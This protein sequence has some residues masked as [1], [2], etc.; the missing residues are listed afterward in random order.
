MTPEQYE[1][2][3][4]LF[5]AAREKD[6][7]QRASFLR[8]ACDDDLVRGEVE[9]LL[10]NDEKADTFLKTPALGS[11]FVVAHPESFAS[12]P[13]GELD[14]GRAPSDMT[15]TSVQRHPKRLGRY[16]ILD[17][18]G[19]G[20][21]GVVYRAEQDN[22]RRTVALKVI[23]PGIESPEVLKRFEHEGQVLGWLQHPGIAQIYEAGTA[24]A[25]QGPQP[26]FA[27]ELVRGTPLTDYAHT[28]RQGVRQR[29]ELIASV[30]DAVHHAHQK[31]VIHR[32]LKPTNI[33]VEESG[34][35]KILD[36][37]VARAT[38]AD[39]RTTTLQ[40]AAGQL[41]GTLAYMS[42]EQIGGDP[43]ELDTRS[44]VYALGAISYE[45]LTG[46]VPVDV[47]R[48]T[49]PQAA[50]AIVEQEP[51][52]LRSVN[53][54]YR[55]DVEAI[56][57][58]ALEKDKSR[59]Y[60]SAAELAADI[61]RY[62]AN[63][64]ISARPVTTAYQLRKFAQRNKALVGGLAAVFVVL[65]I[66]IIGTSSQTVRATRERNRARDA[67]RLADQRRLE[68]ERQHT[69]ALRQTAIAQA[70]NDFLNND[71]LAAVEPEEQGRDVTVRQVL[72]RASAAIGGKFDNQPL[73]EAAVHTTIGQAY[74]SLGLYDEAEPHLDAAVEIGKRVQGEEH[75]ETLASLSN[76]ALLRKRQG[77]LKE[78]ERIARH[79]VETSRRVLGEEYPQTIQATN[80]LAVL[81]QV[82]GQPEEAEALIRRTVETQQRTHGND[83]P[84]TLTAMNNLAIFLIDNGKAEQ[85][86]P[87]LRQALET[88]RRVLRPE[89]PDTITTLSNLAQALWATS[90]PLEATPLFRQVVD[91]RR[92]VL[93]NDHPDTLEAMNNLA[94]ILRRTGTLA[95]SEA[96]FRETLAAQR[97]C[98]GQD[99]YKTLSTMGNLA[100]VLRDQKQ[101]EEGETLL[102]QCLE[103]LRGK[104]GAGHPK[105]LAAMNNLATLLQ[106]AGKLD[107][108]EPLLREALDTLR[109]LVGEEHP[110]VL[111]MMNNLAYQL[112]WQ[113]K[114]EEAA[115]MHKRAVELATRALPDGHWHIGVFQGAYGDCLLDLKRYDEAEEQYLASYECLKAVF[116]ETQGAAADQGAEAPRDSA[117]AATGTPGTVQGA[118]HPVVRRAVE[119]LAALYSTW[120][121]PEEAA[122]W[123]AKLP[124]T[125]PA[126]PPEG[127]P[128]AP[129][130]TSGE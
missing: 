9:S 90:R 34:Q 32:D 66:G 35:P 65:V 85:A 1:Q 88:Q 100:G 23:R 53:R 89:H 19:Q 49:L 52:L 102:R 83:D 72:D 31:G 96:L 106:D 16:R 91:L 25:G 75:P 117:R 39:I 122:S 27:M 99:H 124:T 51:A 29:L 113:G 130:A 18:L 68:A 43:Q 60:Q 119:R 56:V 115:E 114:L 59:R 55:G 57:A 69:E 92:R 82:A 78:A 33:L 6:R 3:R 36:F 58:K 126:A 13:T 97:R 45:L 61:R 86:E 4:E 62:L 77:R 22:P 108:A 50:R 84:A 7:S 63:Q 11:G 95:E 125:Q 73:V 15:L 101:Y 64:P 79:T 74:S 105:T 26:F 81:L 17:V 54:V 87:L 24:D 103:G 98:L 107:E 41:V 8:S 70:V 44:D 12:A 127:P 116:G 47:S 120:E 118:M 71:L 104:L 21:M 128:E 2:I 37:G 40:T 121:K 10:A 111:A 20:G 14:V 5:L 123:Q 109:G 46:R 76:M 129:P 110:T 67:E 112:R 93:G 28:R 30:C 48:K 38:D 42:P 80:N 94:N